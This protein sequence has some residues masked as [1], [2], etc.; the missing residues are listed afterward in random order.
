MLV[1]IFSAVIHVSNV[2]YGGSYRRDGDG[3][4]PCSMCNQS[5]SSLRSA[6]KCCSEVPLRYNDLKSLASVR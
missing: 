4:S 1:E 6:R 3:V 2:E 5:K